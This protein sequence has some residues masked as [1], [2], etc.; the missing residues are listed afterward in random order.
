MRESNYVVLTE[1]IGLLMVSRKEDN[2]TESD[3]WWEVM[4]YDG[5]NDVDHY[6]GW[7]RGLVLKPMM[8][9][10]VMPREKESVVERVAWEDRTV[11]HEQMGFQVV[12][13]CVWQSARVHVFDGKGMEDRRRSNNNQICRCL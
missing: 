9:T 12:C 13:L 10:D 7:E 1:A 5:A 3:D 4:E 2:R 6:G 8:T 11:S